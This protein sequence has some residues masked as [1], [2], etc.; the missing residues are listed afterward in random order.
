MV[1]NFLFIVHL[2][3]WNKEGGLHADLFLGCDGPIKKPTRATA[4]VKI[5]SNEQRET[6][7]QGSTISI[8]SSAVKKFFLQ[9]NESPDT[10]QKKLICASLFFRVALCTS[11][12]IFLQSRIIVVANVLQKS[13]LICLLILLCFWQETKLIL[14]LK[15]AFV[16]SQYSIFK[17]HNLRYSNCIL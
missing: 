7:F 3:D 4:S 9:W 8:I 5:G 2:A 13:S 11:G 12:I 14:F 17:A 1:S 6:L 16:F 15:C 10:R